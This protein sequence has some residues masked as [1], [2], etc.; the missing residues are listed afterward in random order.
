MSKEDL[1]R[2]CRNCHKTTKY[3]SEQ[4]YY[5]AEKNNHLCRD[6]GR[7]EGKRSEGIKINKFI[8]ILREKGISKL[9]E[10][11]DRVIDKLR[12]EYEESNK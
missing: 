1:T 5:Y 2:N 10:E 12:R 4:G 7:E 6:C 11:E 3:K 8:L 9:K